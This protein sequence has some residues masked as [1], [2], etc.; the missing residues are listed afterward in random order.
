MNSVVQEIQKMLEKQAEKDLAL[1]RKEGKIA[2]TSLKVGNVEIRYRKT[3]APAGQ[4]MIL[5]FNNTNFAHVVGTKSVAMKFLVEN[6]EVII[7]G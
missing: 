7:N 3:A 2:V 1:A 6:Y 4:Y 5:D